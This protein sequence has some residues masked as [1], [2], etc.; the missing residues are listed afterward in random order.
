MPLTNKEK[1]TLWV[2]AIIK[3]CHFECRLEH[4]LVPECSSPPPGCFYLGCW[5]LCCQCFWVKWA[6]SLLWIPSCTRHKLYKKDHFTTTPW[7]NKQDKQMFC[8]RKVELL[9][10]AGLN[11]IFRLRNFTP[12]IILVLIYTFNA[13]LSETNATEKKTVLQLGSHN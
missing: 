7:P 1:Q 6:S 12:C 4:G 5:T 10:P 3:S 2:L 9:L 13:H 8:C 11:L